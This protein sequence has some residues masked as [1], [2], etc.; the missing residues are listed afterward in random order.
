MTKRAYVAHEADVPSGTLVRLFLDAVERFGD[1]PAFRFF[2]GPGPDTVD[3][4]YR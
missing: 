4:S 1:A 2:P 3:V